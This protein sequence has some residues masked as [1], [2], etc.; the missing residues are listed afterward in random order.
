MNDFIN[1]FVEFAEGL[2]GITA[3]EAHA[4]EWKIEKRVY[5]TFKTVEITISRPLRPE[6]V[7]DEE[8]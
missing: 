8:K 7:E 5:E 1:K 4:G 6:E 2:E 3:I